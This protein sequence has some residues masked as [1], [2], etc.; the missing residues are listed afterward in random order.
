LPEFFALIRREMGFSL[1][2]RFASGLS[3]SL[4]GKI[5]I[6]VFFWVFPAV[7]LISAAF[8]GASFLETLATYGHTV[9]LAAKTYGSVFYDKW[10]PAIAR[11]KW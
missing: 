3:T 2:A 6:S 11:G 8:I 1:N 5:G 9:L 10:T 4:F 7:G